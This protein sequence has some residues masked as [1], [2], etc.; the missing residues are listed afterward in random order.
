VKRLL[1]GEIGEHE[2]AREIS[3][4]EPALCHFEIFLGFEGDIERYGATRSNHWFYESWD[5]DDGI[6][7]SLDRPIPMMF[8]S[9][10]SLQDAAHDPGPSQCH[11]G[12]FTTLADW[13]SGADFADGGASERA[14]EWAAFMTDIE[15]KMGEHHLRLV[16]ALF[17]LRTGRWWT[18]L[19]ESLR[20]R[21]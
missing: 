18:A 10:P 16:L 21:V 6:W 3:T 11:T 8:V 5:I 15:T 20:T 14:D 2:W 12:E 9:F 1:P 13:S 4:F 7:S 17:P 19:D